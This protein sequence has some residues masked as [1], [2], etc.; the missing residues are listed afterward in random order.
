VEQPAQEGSHVCRAAFW[1]SYQT[2]RLRETDYKDNSKW[3]SVIF[4]KINKERI[5]NTK[6]T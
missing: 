3:V 1:E 2:N 4:K 6:E 5:E